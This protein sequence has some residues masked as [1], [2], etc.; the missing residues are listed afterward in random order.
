MKKKIV[1]TYNDD[2]PIYAVCAIAEDIKRNY[3]DYEKVEALLF[4]EIEVQE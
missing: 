4:E 3:V 2:F 1:I